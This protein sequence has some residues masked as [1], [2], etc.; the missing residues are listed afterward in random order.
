MFRTINGMVVGFAAILIFI[1]GCNS[2][3]DN[4]GPT[5]TPE[6]PRVTQGATKGTEEEHAHKPGSHGGNIVEIGRDNFHAEAVFEKGGIRLYILGKDEARV[7]EVESQIL[8][9]YAKGTGA[10]EAV[11]FIMSPSPQSG[12]TEG[13]TSQ[14]LGKLPEGLLGKNLEVTVPSI[15]VNGDRFRFGFSSLSDDHGDVPAKVVDAEERQLYLTPGGKYTQADIKANGVVTAS[16][17]FKGQ[18]AS[19]DVKPQPGDKICPISLTK[20]NPK[21]S[22]VIS[23]KTYEF[24]CPPCVDEFVKTAKEQPDQVKEPSDYIKK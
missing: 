5:T 14:F 17:K 16:Q 18:M 6:K 24:C 8:T 2:A 11:E 7:Q 12:D 23:G 13:K 9:A 19:H 22:W 3:K 10:T 15:R 21:F 20:A 4:S 1:A